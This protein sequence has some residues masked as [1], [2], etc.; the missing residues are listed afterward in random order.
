WTARTLLKDNDKRRDYYA[1]QLVSIMS[2]SSPQSWHPESVLRESYKGWE[3]VTN[4]VSLKPQSSV[5]F[6]GAIGDTRYTEKYKIENVP[7]EYAVPVL[8]GWELGY[9]CTDHHVRDIGVAIREWRYERAPQATQGTLYYTLDFQLGDD[10][11]NYSYG[12]ASIDVFG[13][14]ARGLEPHPLDVSK[15]GRSTLETAP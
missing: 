1:G 14:N 7:F 13:M 5:S 10:D 8:K 3:P 12:R 9:L 15:F 6:C 2:Y 11:D 4:R